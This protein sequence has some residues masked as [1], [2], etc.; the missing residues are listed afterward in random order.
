MR[1]HTIGSIIITIL[2][3]VISLGLVTI[4]YYILIQSSHDVCLTLDIPSWVCRADM[5]MDCS[6]CYGL[7]ILIPTLFIL[8]CS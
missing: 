5:V 1:Q 8:F 4:Q 2:L 6:G 7:A 3:F